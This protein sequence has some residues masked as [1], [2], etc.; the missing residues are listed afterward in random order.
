MKKRKQGIKPITW[1]FIAV[2]VL[3]SCK[4][5]PQANPLPTAQ[6]RSILI[7]EQSSEAE[8]RNIKEVSQEIGE[9][10]KALIQKHLGV[11]AQAGEP[12]PIEDNEV[13]LLV[14]GPATFEQ[15]FADV[16]GAK[17]SINVEIYIFEQDELGNKMK[18]LLIKK[19]KEGVN[20][21]LI[22]D[23]VGSIKTSQEFFDEMRDV[24]IQV[25]VFNPI[26]PVEGKLLDINNRDHRKLVVVDGK[27]A[28]TGGIN[29]SSVYSR[30][31]AQVLSSGRK[32]K[33][34]PPVP[35]S[36]QNGWRDTQIKVT[37]PAVAEM[38]NV[39]FTT[40]NS[41]QDEK[42]DDSSKP[43]TA[44]GQRDYYPKLQRTGDKILRVIASGPGDEKNII[45]SDFL[46]AI[47][48]HL[49]ARSGR[50]LQKY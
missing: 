7:R 12:L 15:V 38:Q 3:V 29:I 37:G 10:K 4:T 50:A 43:L 18:D 40:W 23:S 39:F 11:I 31:S 45:Y 19:Q 5:L 27:I 35:I 22:Y 25:A 20:V 46:M 41:L 1:F 48:I 17:H 14:D 8:K 16:G 2:G 34:K 42:I 6:P 13:K 26:N 44:T 9:E 49:S 30:G 47:K 21:K 33:N 28:F 36:S 24:G 32:N